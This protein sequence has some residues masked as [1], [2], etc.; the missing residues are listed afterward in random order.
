ME[1][2]HDLIAASTWILATLPLLALAV[3]VALLTPLALAAAEVPRWLVRAA[4]VAG[5][6]AA[7]GLALDAGVLAVIA[8]APYAALTVVAGVLG[9][10][11]LLATRTDLAICAGLMFLPGAATWLVAHRAGYPLLGYP[12]F[13]VILTAAHFHVAGAYL[14]III[15]RIAQRGPAFARAVAIGCVAAVPVTAAGIYGPAWLELGGA[16]AMAAC[17][18]GAGLAILG[19]GARARPAGAVLL[20]TMVLAGVFALRLHGAPAIRPGGLDPLAAMLL[21][22]GVPNTLLFAAVALVALRKR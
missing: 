20:V 13:W 22:H 19:S 10:R 11:R 2:S 21:A 7:A 1:R 12:P 14:A 16:L 8:T 9:A 18:F 3:M 4:W 15:G 6:L 5:P 17:G